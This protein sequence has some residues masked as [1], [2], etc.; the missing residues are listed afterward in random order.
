[1]LYRFEN[2]I[3][4]YGRPLSQKSGAAAAVPAAPPPTAL[5]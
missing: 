3:V 4:N 1:M 5:I 2:N